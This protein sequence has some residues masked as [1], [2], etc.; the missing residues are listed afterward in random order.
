MSNPKTLCII[1]DDSIYQFAVKRTLEADNIA[2]KVLS[3]ADGEEAMDFFNQNS[4]DSENLPDIIF[5]DINMPI[6]DGWQFLDEY[7]LI[8]PRISKT[9]T[10]YMVS[11]SVDSAD[12]EKAKTIKQVSGYLIKPITTGKLKEVLRALDNVA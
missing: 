5:L 11:S 4:A 10:I 12:L 7:V 2:C 6:M 8:K 1:D 3:F 9:I